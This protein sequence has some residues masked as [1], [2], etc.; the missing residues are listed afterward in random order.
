MRKLAQALLVGSLLACPEPTFIPDAGAGGGMSGGSAAAGGMS[1]GGSS[2]G[3]TAGGGTAG[4][5]AAGGGGGLPPG[6]FDSSTWD[7]ASYH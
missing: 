4:G 2:A 7:N 5:M 3:G 1:G 6:I